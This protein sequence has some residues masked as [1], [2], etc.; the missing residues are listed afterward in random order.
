MNKKKIIIISSV[1]VAGVIAYYIY[2]SIRLKRRRN[3]VIVE[4]QE[5]IIEEEV[6]PIESSY[7]L[8]MVTTKTSNLN[9][10]RNPTTS[11]PIVDSLKRG[12]AIM[13]KPFT[14]AWFEV[15]KDGK[16][17]FGYASAQ[18]LTKK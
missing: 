6:K 12:S 10:R 1:V 18:Y 9:V 14:D 16:S 4:Q 2:S 13:A 7:D 8:Y 11:S 17:S 15:S 5:E 3:D